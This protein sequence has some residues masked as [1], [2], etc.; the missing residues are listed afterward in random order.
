MLYDIEVTQYL[1]KLHGMNDQRSFTQ[2]EACCSSG[3]YTEAVTCRQLAAITYSLHCCVELAVT[4]NLTLHAGVRSFESCMQCLPPR[5]SS[6]CCP[7]SALQSRQQPTPQRTR[8]SLSSTRT[9]LLSRARSVG[10]LCQLPLLP[11]LLRTASREHCTQSRR[12][13]DLAL[14]RSGQMCLVDSFQMRC[15]EPC[16]GRLAAGIAQLLQDQRSR[17]RF[18]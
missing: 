4:S 11:A 12:C 3:R 17:R 14:L 2:D 10:Q 7:P 16:P 18:E 6:R 8:H 9:R 1:H 15:R 13:C 5:S